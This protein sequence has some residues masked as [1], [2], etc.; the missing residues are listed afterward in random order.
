[1]EHDRRSSVRRRT[2]LPFAW[3]PLDGPLPAV[4]VCDALGIPRALTLQSR[5]A[6]L[7]EAFTTAMGAL[8]EPPTAQALRLL[9]GKLGV[10]AEAVLAQAPVPDTGELELSADGVG[11]RAG[12]PLEPGRWVG[13]HL[14]LPVSYHVVCVAR[15][16]RCTAAAA[17]SY[18]IGAGF[19]GLEPPLE[20]RL[21]RFAISR[22]RAAAE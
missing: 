1:M 19:E 21:T 3:C 12:R 16:N 6:D 5:L 2:R 8:T 11:F 4:Q 9:D 22:D 10:V 15:V 18:R 13:V 20:R 7:D 17:G 14:V